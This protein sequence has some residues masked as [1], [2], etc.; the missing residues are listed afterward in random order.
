VIDALANFAMPQV[1]VYSVGPTN[2]SATT[3]IYSKAPQK[4]TAMIVAHGGQRPTT[5][6]DRGVPH[7]GEV[8]NFA[9]LVPFRNQLHRS[10]PA[11]AGNEW[12]NVAAGLLK[13]HAG[14]FSCVGIPPLYLQPHAFDNLNTD[15][16]GKGA[17]WRAA[18]ENFDIVV[19]EDM[20]P[21][22]TGE[23]ELP[24]Y[25]FLNSD[26]KLSTRYQSFLMHC[27]RVESHG[28]GQK[29]SGNGAVPPSGVYS[30]DGAVSYLF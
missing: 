28:S 17:V 1:F 19:L 29:C 24:L 22:T 6:P 8:L 11:K 5:G 23:P 30:Y 25:R 16:D 21:W 13:G 4:Q 9:F 27:C 7:G 26:P 10:T 12:P 18:L 20:Q 3:H 15:Y 2:A 14:E